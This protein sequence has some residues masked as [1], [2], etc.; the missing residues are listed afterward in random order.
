MA[1]LDKEGLSY[2][3]SKTKKYVDDTINMVSI[4]LNSSNWTN[5]EQT[6]TVDGIVVDETEQLITPVPSADSQD[7]YYSCGIV[8]NGQA[9]NSLT[10]KAD[11]VPTSNLTVYVAIQE[12]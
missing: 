6:V 1:F 4:T 8:C 12:V 7:E 10:F 3:W 9:E 11:E 2:F 5:N